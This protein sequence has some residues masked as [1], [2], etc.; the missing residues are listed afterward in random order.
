MTKLYCQF[1]AVVTGA[2]SPK[3]LG[4]R[5]KH[6]NFFQN[7]IPQSQILLKCVSVCVYM[8]MSLFNTRSYLLISGL[9]GHLFSNSLGLLHVTCI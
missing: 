2:Y 3:I 5:V 6:K 7:G 4:A 9:R 1:T 8:Y